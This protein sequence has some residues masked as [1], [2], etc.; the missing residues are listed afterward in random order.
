MLLTKKKQ[1]KPQIKKT[2]KTHKTET[3]T[4]PPKNPKQTRKRKKKTKEKKEEF[5]PTISILQKL[6]KKGICSIFFKCLSQCSDTY[7]YIIKYYFLRY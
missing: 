5:V 1:K 3:R 6:L 4:I 7:D 2:E